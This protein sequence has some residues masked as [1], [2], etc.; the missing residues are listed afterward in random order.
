MSTPQS[1][2]RRAKYPSD[3]S[4]NGWKKLQKVLPPSKTNLSFA[5]FLIP[6]VEP[7]FH[8]KRIGC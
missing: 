3:M 4:K 6:F 7:E 2:P 1:T 8:L 5:E